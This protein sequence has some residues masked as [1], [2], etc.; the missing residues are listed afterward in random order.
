VIIVTGMHRSGTSALCG[1]L[2]RIGVDFGAPSTLLPADGWNERGYF[3]NREVFLLNGFAVT[4]IRRL[5]KIWLIPCERRNLLNRLLMVP[6]KARYLSMPRIGK[7][8]ARLEKVKD[9]VRAVAEEMEHRAVKDPRFCLL[10]EAWCRHAPVDKVLFCHRHPAAVALSLKHREG[11]PLRLGYR[12][13][14]YHVA[15]FLDQVDRTGVKTTY[16]DFDRLFDPD[17]QTGEAAGLFRFAGHD[18]DS[19]RWK[20]IASA[21]LDAALRHHQNEDIRLPP[22][23][24]SLLAE[25]KRRRRRGDG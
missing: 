9:E 2:S 8:A 18:F 17:G 12:F 5:L 7:I 11:L 14:H 19:G 21:S 22:K 25:L 16:V 1:L 6:V 20:R 13:W 15:S 4:G 10:L 23:T 3:E 24:A